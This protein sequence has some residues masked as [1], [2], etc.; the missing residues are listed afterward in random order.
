MANS[1]LQDKIFKVPDK[2]FNKVNQMLNKINVDDKQAKG[3]RRAKDIVND[4]NVTYSNMKR[5]KNYFDNYSGDG[6][7]NE[8]NLIGGKITRK[9][10]DETL[11]QDRESIKKIKKTKKDGGL[12]NQFLKTHEKDSDNTNPTNPNSGMVDITKG[13]T[14]NNIMTGDVIYKSSDNKQ[15]AYNKEINSIKYLIEYMNKN[16][17]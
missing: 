5:L 11:G 16:K 17:K 2:V 13:S 10:V 14:L 12:E 3:L 9:W 6:S 7:D 8:F 1:K 15:E 4:R